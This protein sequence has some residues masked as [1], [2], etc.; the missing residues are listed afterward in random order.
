MNEMNQKKKKKR[1]I[2]NLGPEM[3]SKVEEGGHTSDPITT[4]MF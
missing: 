2:R 3:G 4:T 1:K